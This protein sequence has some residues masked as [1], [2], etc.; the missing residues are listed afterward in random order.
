M[1]ERA[2]V[3]LRQ[4]VLS[5]KVVSALTDEPAN[6]GLLL[7]AKAAP[8]TRNLL[9]KSGGFLASLLV[10]ERVDLHSNEVE[11]SFSA[12]SAAAA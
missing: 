4:P 11:V 9:L 3:L 1:V 7:T 6:A 5:A 10:V 8:R 12:P 2:R